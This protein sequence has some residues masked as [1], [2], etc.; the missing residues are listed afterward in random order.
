M[1][2]PIRT[3]PG[4]A[5]T[6]VHDNTYQASE[7]TRGPWHPD[8]QHAGPPIALACRA[9]ENAAR[10]NGLT[11]VARLTANLLRPIPIGSITTAVATD[12][13][14]RN[15]GH[16]SA[17]LIADG[18]EVARF[19]ALVQ[20][21]HAVRL[22]ESR[23]D[24]SID[25]L[26]AIAPRTLDASPACTLPFAGPHVGYA[27]LVETRLAKGRIFDG[28]CAA[29][30]RLCFP[31]VQGEPTSDYQRIAV[32]ADSGNGISAPLDFAKYIFV[33]ADLTIN[34]LRKPLG[35]WIC[36]DAHSRVTP[37][38]SGVTAS[39]LFDADGLI[40]FATQSLAVRQ[41]E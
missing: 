7:L 2:E 9:I 15:A 36:L 12:H 13:A 17:Q 21:E 19:T 3:L 27:D 24:S 28:P 37:T 41:R 26:P 4:S 14:G 23:L 20:R 1:T 33:N 16:Y 34:F 18:K 35:D 40:G 29:W 25:S 32:F 6:R 22:P 30:F 8:H 5:Y 39:R 38:G 31:L 11:H 10:A